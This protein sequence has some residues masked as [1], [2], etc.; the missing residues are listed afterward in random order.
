M[1][2]RRGYVTTIR[3]FLKRWMT[4][5]FIH[6]VKI[7]CSMFTIYNNNNVQQISCAGCSV[8]MNKFQ[9]VKKL[10]KQFFL[11]KLWWSLIIEDQ[12]FTSQWAVCLRL[13]G[14]SGFGMRQDRHEAWKSEIRWINVMF[15]AFNC[16]PSDQRLK[17]TL[18]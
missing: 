14:N 18:S 13:H 5:A 12:F 7:V 4:F 2:N 10:A 8:K 9:I 1:A 15:Y 3:M 16:S 6:F 11:V 17:I